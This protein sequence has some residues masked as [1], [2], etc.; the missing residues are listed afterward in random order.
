MFV[1]IYMYAVQEGK[2]KNKINKKLL[3][4]EV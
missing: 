3:V 2:N 1:V 4:P